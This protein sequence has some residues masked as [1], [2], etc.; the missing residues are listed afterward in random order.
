MGNMV[1]CYEVCMEFSNGHFDSDETFIREDSH[2]WEAGPFLT[3]DDAVAH[4]MK[5]FREGAK[6]DNG[7][8]HNIEKGDSKLDVIY[9]FLSDNGK[10]TNRGSEYSCIVLE[11]NFEL[12]EF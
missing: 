3:Q 5:C 10:P 6:K 4:A 8:L 9:R 1:K 7:R 12:T 11:R 2:K